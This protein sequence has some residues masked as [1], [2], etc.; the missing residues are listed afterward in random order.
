MTAHEVAEHWGVSLGTVR[1]W[2]KDYYGGSGTRTGKRVKIRG[3][4]IHRVR[5]GPRR[6]YFN[7]QE[8]EGLKM[9]K[10]G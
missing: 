3:P 10:V 5:V 7:R 8:V 6:I 1:R 4:L 2:S 9:A